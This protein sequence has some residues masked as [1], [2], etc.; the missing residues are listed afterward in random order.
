MT[1]AKRCLSAA[2]DALGPPLPSLESC[3]PPCPLPHVLIL[4][5]KPGLLPQPVCV[6]LLSVHCG[7]LLL[8][9]AGSLVTLWGQGGEG[10][11]PR[12]YSCF[13]F[14]GHRVCFHGV[15]A[16][17]GDSE[18][19]V[20]YGSDTEDTKIPFPSSLLALRDSWGCPNTARDA[21]AGPW[22]AL[23]LSFVGMQPAA[24]H[25]L[26][27]SWSPAR[28]T[29]PPWASPSCCQ[30]SS[31][32]KSVFSSLH[33]LP[34][35]A[36]GREMRLWVSLQSQDLGFFFFLSLKMST[37]PGLQ[38]LPHSIKVLGFF[39]NYLHASG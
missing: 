15:E 26:G 9:V 39:V 38:T 5:S 19:S 23:T 25:P 10:E 30:S 28:S 32:I 21:G 13:P 12:P 20:P 35:L 2:G 29:S 22:A 24:S 4:L 31:Q 33:L 16:A 6:S 11:F 27:A 14:L 17:G 1:V 37:P 34:C 7:L 36:L 8:E 3:F 18:C